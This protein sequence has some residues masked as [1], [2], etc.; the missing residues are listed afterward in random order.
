MA[1][2]PHSMS[3]ERR[4]QLQARLGEAEEALHTLLIAKSK[5]QVRADTGEQIVYTPADEAKLRGYIRELEH[6]LGL[7][8]PAT[9]APIGFRI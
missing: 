3:D 4:S 8:S 2:T 6:K 5:V 7:R 1:L 9:D